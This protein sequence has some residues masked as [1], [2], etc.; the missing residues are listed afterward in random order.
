MS[1]T[2]SWTGLG[3]VDKFFGTIFGLFK[4]YVYFI[5]LFMLLSFVHPHSRW[6]N[7]LK[8]GTFFD[9]I[10]WGKGIL[11][12]NIPKRYEYIEKSK[13]NVDKITK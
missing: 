13:E 6:P 3:S 5:F 1:K 10:L 8:N 2:I 4:G 11:E 7:N 9:S 12:E